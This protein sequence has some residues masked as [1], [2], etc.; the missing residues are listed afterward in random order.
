[1]F[2]HT[3]GLILGIQISV[4]LLVLLS[5]SVAAETI[6]HH[7]GS[8]DYGYYDFKDFHANVGDR[9]EID[10]DSDAPVDLIMTTEDGFDQYNDPNEDTF[11]YLIKGT[12]MRTSST[13]L[14]FDIPVEGRYYFI[15]DNSAIPEIG[16]DP[17]GTVNYTVDIE[18]SMGEL[19][20]GLAL[21]AVLFIAAIVV[22]LVFVRRYMV[23]RA[24]ERA[25]TYEHSPVVRPPEEQGPMNC[26][27]CG[28]YSSHG[29]HCTKCGRRLR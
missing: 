21:C 19:Q 14:S 20:Y 1:M 28:T 9:I 27:E 16:A 23:R 25:A 8:I 7:G 4:I 2:K 12:V 15:I 26:P 18:R 22:G 5:Q 29:K 10:F 13:T 17:V 3:P 24:R 11:E 6:W